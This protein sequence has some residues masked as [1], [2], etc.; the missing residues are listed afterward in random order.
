MVELLEPLA[1][2]RGPEMKNR[3]MLAPLTN[4]QSD[5][6]GML[7]DNELNWLSMRAEGGFGLTMTCAAYVQANR[8]MPGQIAMFS[9]DH[10]ASFKPLVT[11]IRAQQSIAIMQ[12]NQDGIRANKDFI[13]E[14][15]VGPSADE[16]SGARALENSEVKQVIQDYIAAAKRAEQ[17]GFDGVELHGA[18]GYLLCEFFSPIF[19]RRTD[20][21]GGSVENR[22]RILHEI[23][24]GVR[25]RCHSNFI[26]GVRLS[27]ERFGLLFSEVL[28]TAERL[29]CENKIDFL[30]MSL[31][32]IFKE[33]EN[34]THKGRSLIDCFAK[35]Q[36]GNCKLGVA[37]NIRSPKDAERALG[38][39]ADFV[40]LGRAAILHHD[41][42]LRYQNDRCFSPTEPPVTTDYLTRE[43]VTERFVNYLRHWPDLVA[44]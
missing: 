13:K 9:D 23:I 42:P 27:P 7:S 36:R 44:D 24:D 12:L 1:F 17:A 16:K 10:I 39:G 21:Y 22:W 34:D 28:D 41:F 33:P 31:W 11:K 35:L 15:P 25:E 43:G 14:V 5:K 6:N 3:F 8:G 38:C 20:E 26:L 30:D 29:M 18:H 32:D 19:N 40:A 2:A 37:G 4:F